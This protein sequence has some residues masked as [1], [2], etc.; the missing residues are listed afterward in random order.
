MT[1]KKVKKQ[2]DQVVEARDSY[3]G[4]RSPYWDYQRTHG[5]NGKGDDIP[6]CVQA[7]PDVLS[8]TEITTPSTPQLVMGEAVEHLQGRQKEVYFLTMRED[9]SLAEVAE[10]LGIEKGSAQKYKER[11]IKFIAGYCKQAIKKG[12]V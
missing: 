2:K 12:R 6:E 3:R 1:H 11:A 9:K 4:E 10:I 7:N 5:G 8:E